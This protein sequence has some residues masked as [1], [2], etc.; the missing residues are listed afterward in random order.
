MKKILKKLTS[1]TMFLTMVVMTMKNKWKVENMRLA[2]FASQGVVN[3]SRIKYSVCNA[4]DVP[5]GAPTPFEYV[6]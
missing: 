4:V 1:V 6:K 3:G 2:V 5:I